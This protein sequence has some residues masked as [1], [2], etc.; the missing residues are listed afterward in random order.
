MAIAII[1]SWFF[2]RLSLSK[3][4][5]GLESF[6]FH[7]KSEKEWEYKSGLKRRWSRSRLRWIQY[8]VSTTISTKKCTTWTKPCE[9]SIFVT[10]KYLET[11]DWCQGW[12]YLWPL[13]RTDDDLHLQQKQPS[14]L[15]NGSGLA[16]RT[17][18]LTRPEGTSSCASPLTTKS[19][20]CHLMFVNTNFSGARPLP[21]QPWH[22]SSASLEEGALQ[23]NNKN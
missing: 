18:K 15:R 11:P 8:P 1:T 4:Q 13:W 23:N 20:P 16:P 17:S 9:S 21:L 5:G 2:D 12:E 6:T 10:C 3:F 14:V 19:T 7:W 22:H